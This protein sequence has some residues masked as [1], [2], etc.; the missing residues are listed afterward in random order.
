MASVPPKNS[1]VTIVIIGLHRVVQ[2]RN[3]SE[4]TI[5]HNPLPIYSEEM[6][7]RNVT[8]ASLSL[9]PQNNRNVSTTIAVTISR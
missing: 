8:H 2:S 3:H 6:D 4:H 9:N 5:N 1:I 7:S